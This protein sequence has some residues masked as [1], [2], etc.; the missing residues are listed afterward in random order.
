MCGVVPVHDMHSLGSK[1]TVSAMVPPGAELA[2][3]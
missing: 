3:E 1:V 2:L